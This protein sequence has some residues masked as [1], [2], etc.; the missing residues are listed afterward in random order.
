[1]VEKKKRK[2]ESAHGGLLSIL[3]TNSNQYNYQN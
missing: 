1:M 2:R 3:K